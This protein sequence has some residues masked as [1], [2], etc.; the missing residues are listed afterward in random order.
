MFC[1][2]LSCSSFRF[3]PFSLVTKYMLIPLVLASWEGGGVG[4]G[5]VWLYIGISEDVF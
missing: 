2:H 4:L 1:P 5:E 3:S